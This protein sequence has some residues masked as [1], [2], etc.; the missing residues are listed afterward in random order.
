MEY[1]KSREL[2]NR[3][4]LSLQKMYGNRLK[5]LILYGDYAKIENP[6]KNQIK[7]VAVLNDP[8]ISVFNE[9]DQLENIINPLNKEYNCELDVLPTTFQRYEDISQGLFLNVRKEGIPI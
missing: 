3:L 1:N 4:K 5:E 6:V 2:L 8:E 9:I 7:L